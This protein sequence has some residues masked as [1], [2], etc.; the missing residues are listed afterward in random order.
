[1]KRRRIVEELRDFWPAGA[2]CPVVFCDVVKDE[3]EFLSASE[4]AK[5]T[6]K[7][8]LERRRGRKTD[9]HS[10]CNPGEAEKAVR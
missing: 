9:P 10:K 3:R 5:T 2:R 6:V 4:K 8:G 7:K 1:M